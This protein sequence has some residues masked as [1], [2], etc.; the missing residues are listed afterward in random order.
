MNKKGIDL[1]DFIVN[2]SAT[3]HDIANEEFMT[4]S[5]L[6]VID[7]DEVKNQYIAKLGTRK[8]AAPKSNDALYIK[9]EENIYFIEFK[10]G[11]VKK[12]DLMQKNYD[13]TLILSDIISKHI[14]FMKENITYILV[15]NTDKNDFKE[16]DGK[17]V[18]KSKN[19]DFIGANLAKLSNDTF[20]KFDLGFF[21]NYLFADVFTL[22]QKDFEEQFIAKW[23][24]DC[25]KDIITL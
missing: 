15:Y 7:F 20:I 25:E 23:Q 1:N 2:L 16:I 21:K 3:S 22:S 5:N 11:K 10:N 4:N 24:V 14:S 6:K 13:S 8:E 18:D 19:R 9:S 17:L 12:Y